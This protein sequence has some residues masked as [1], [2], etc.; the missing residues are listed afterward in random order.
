MMFLGTKRRRIL[1]QL[2]DGHGLNKGFKEMPLLSGYISPN[3]VKYFRTLHSDES[4]C[5]HRL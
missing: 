4:K 3:D 1:F 5:L 2:N